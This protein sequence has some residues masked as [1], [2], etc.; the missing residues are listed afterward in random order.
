MRLSDKERKILG[1]AQ[2]RAD[3]SLQTIAKISGYREHS[4]RYALES[5]KSRKII[6]KR[7]MINVRLLGLT[8]FAI[9]FSLANQGKEVR[10]RFLKALETDDKVGWIREFGGELPFVFD[11]IVPSI[12]DV[13]FMLERLSRQFGDIFFEKSLAVRYGISYFERGYL[14]QQPQEAPIEEGPTTRLVKI[15]DLDHRILS[16]LG[17]SA[18]HSE[19]ALARLLGV[20]LSTLKY[21]LSNLRSAGV[22]LASY[23]DI[24]PRLAGLHAYR[25]LISTR[26]AHPDQSAKLREYFRAH[27]NFVSLIMCM[28]AWDYETTIEVE[29]PRQATELVSELYDSHDHFIRSIKVLPVFEEPKDSNYPFKLHPQR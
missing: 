24:N 3:A 1:A 10:K 15:D 16:Y 13:H 18:Q 11:V 26:G 23:Y 12:D 2:F 9:F 6:E 14:A 7:V 25:L 27:P 4:V 22:L 21:R 5:L 8:R 29:D 28:G 20:P 19:R 17:E